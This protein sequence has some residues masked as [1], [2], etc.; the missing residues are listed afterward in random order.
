MDLTT[1][2]RDMRQTDRDARARKEHRVKTGQDGRV[3]GLNESDHMD[4]GNEE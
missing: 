4:L 3:V 1:N 2:R